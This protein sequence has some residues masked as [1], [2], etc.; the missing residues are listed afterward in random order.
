[1][2]QCYAQL[3]HAPRSSRGEAPYPTVQA[4]G[5]LSWL[6]ILGDVI[7]TVKKVVP[8]RAAQDELIGKIN[9]TFADAA[10]KQAEM[11]LAEINSGDK[12]ASR[13][14]PAIG[15][16]CVAGLGLHFLV[17][18]VLSGIL[19]ASGGLAVASPLDVE[20]LTTLVMTLLGLGGLRTVEKIKKVA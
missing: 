12:F 2:W 11:T 18:P 4:M 15:W 3:R 9:Q 6:P 13:W 20:S 8:D 16:V 10:A 1:M 7:D 5:L 14:R 19:M 17:Y